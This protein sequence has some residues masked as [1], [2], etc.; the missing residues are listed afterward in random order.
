MT[1][2]VHHSHVWTWGALLPLMGIAIQDFRSRQIWVGW[3][4]MV[5]ATA[6]GYGLSQFSISFLGAHWLLS[7]AFVAYE[8]GM[9]LVYLRWKKGIWSLK[10]FLGLGDV[11]FWLAIIPF[12]NLPGFLLFHILSLVF[13]ITFHLLFTRKQARLGAKVPLAGMQAFFLSVWLCVDAWSSW[14]LCYGLF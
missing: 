8:V 5:F 11:I 4:P 6:L 3:F 7:A 14:Q 1:G 13:A 9:V 12:F 10:G 2:W